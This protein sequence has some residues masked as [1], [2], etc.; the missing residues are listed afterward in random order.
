MKED[1]PIY[2]FDE[3]PTWLIEE[4][5]QK[6]NGNYCSLYSKKIEIMEGEKAEVHRCAGNSAFCDH[7]MT[8][9]LILSDNRS[10]LHKKV[11][12]I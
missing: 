6:R 9:A 7:I 1:L 2:T 4:A 5:C 3:T 12:K 8:T 10:K 11:I